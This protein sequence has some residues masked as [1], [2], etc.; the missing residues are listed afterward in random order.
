MT[1]GY[2]AICMTLAERAVLRIREEMAARGLSQRDLA[3]LLHCSQGR[4][5]KLLTGGVKLRLNDVAVLADAVGI[6]AVEAIRDRGVEFFAELS[7]SE[8]RLLER[9]RRQ[10]HKLSCALVLLDVDP[11]APTTRDRRDSP[12]PSRHHGGHQSATD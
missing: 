12:R 4:V 6:T 8:L 3:G 5:A 1:Y 2:A 9:L 7:P 11:S 10:P